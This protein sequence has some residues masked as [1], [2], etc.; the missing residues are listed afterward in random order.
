MEST[1]VKNEREAFLR[2]I[3]NSKHANITQVQTITYS[4]SL[5]A[6]RADFVAGKR[7]IRDGLRAEIFREACKLKNAEARVLQFYVALSQ[8]GYKG[9]VATEDVVSNQV[10]E[11]T[12]G[13]CAPRTFRRALAALCRR[14]WL[15]KTNMATGT[16]IPTDNGWKTLQ[17]NKVT[18]CRCTK[19]L[20]VNQL[21]EKPKLSV[22]PDFDIEQNSEAYHTTRTKIVHSDRPTSEDVLPRPKQPAMGVE[23]QPKSPP[24]HRGG[25]SDCSSYVNFEMQSEIENEES[26]LV[27]APPPETAPPE[28][29]PTLKHKTSGESRKA[30]KT[31]QKA[32]AP[33]GRKHRSKI[34]RTWQNG[35]AL[36]LH[37]LKTA[38]AD[39]L[40]HRI[41]AQQT[42][43]NYPPLFPSALDWDSYVTTWLDRDWK[44][45][46]RTITRE[47]L[48]E[49]EAWC[50]PLRPPRPEDLKLTA[51]LEVQRQAAE[52]VA[53]FERMARIVKSMPEM[54]ISPYTPKWLAEKIA[55]NHWVLSEIPWL[56]CM[57]RMTLADL[58][59]GHLQA[60]SEIAESL[61]LSD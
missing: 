39:D 33:F 23:E 47:L 57:G 32:V 41:A 14:G 18:I 25:T 12:G 40:Q 59:P 4:I 52:Q 1:I 48:P 19:L 8:A 7:G 20:G 43:L 60:F 26:G 21:S 13:L 24:L 15:S 34:P 22:V 10:I 17:V 35:R 50:V 16:K 9:S 53:Q 11:S 3:Q 54:L 46:R 31:A 44:E 36:L 45:R 28:T 37:D 29:S 27:S 5:A 51:P 2:S 61:D 6:H 38:G 55:D 30:G 56:V 58:T 49:L 42:S